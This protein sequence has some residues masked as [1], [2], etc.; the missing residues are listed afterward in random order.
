[1]RGLMDQINTWGASGVPVAIATNVRMRGSGLR[2]LGAKM[3]VA[4]SN[5]FV[6]S[7]SGGCIEGAVIESACAVLKSGQPKLLYFGV[8]D[9]TRPWDIGLTCGT[10]LEVL[11]EPLASASWQTVFADLVQDLQA[12]IP[13]A[14][15]TVISRQKLGRKLLI[16]DQG[17]QAGSLGSDSLDQ[18]AFAWAQGQ[19]RVNSSSTKTIDGVDLFLDIFPPPARM[20]VIGAVHVAIPLVKMASLMGFQTIVI[21]PRSAFAK[22]EGFPQVD[23]MLVEWPQDVLPIL[24]LDQ[25]TYVVALSHDD[26]LD[27]PALAIALQS[28]ARYVG[29]IGARTNIPKRKDIL[30][31][32]GVSDDQLDRLHAPIGLPIGAI[33][34]QEIAISILAEIIAAKYR[35]DNLNQ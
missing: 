29:V 9:D 6:G 7:V 34:P 35:V 19:L 26:K 22:S 33:E 15:V 13:C 3:A 4:E 2:P 12:H 23:R 18:Q 14:L 8:N 10:S 30:R 11:V 1:M 17:I 24:N 32:M 21:D 5:D 27:N 25:G 31:E 16:T 28:E 20:V